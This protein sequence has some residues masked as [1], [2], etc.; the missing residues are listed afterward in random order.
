MTTCTR[1]QG[2]MLEEHMIDMDGDYGE[3]WSRSW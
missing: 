2:L 3:L 1:C